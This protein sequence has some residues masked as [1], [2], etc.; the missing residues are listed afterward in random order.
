MFATVPAPPDEVPEA[1]IASSRRP[2]SPTSQ[3]A[4]RS[5]TAQRSA[6]PTS[7]SRSVSS[8]GSNLRAVLLIRPL[9]V[10]DQDFDDDWVA[11]ATEDVPAVEVEPP[12][13]NV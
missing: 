2:S 12:T 9:G 7:S 4:S 5:T 8:T 6:R 1:E 3:P 10:F 13:A 11:R